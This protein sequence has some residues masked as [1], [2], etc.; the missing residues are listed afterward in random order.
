MGD[1]AATE[2]AKEGWT[3]QGV[4]YEQRRNTGDPVGIIAVRVVDVPDRKVFVESES[5]TWETTLITG[6]KPEYGRFSDDVGGLGPGTYTI[7]PMDIDAQVTVSLARGDFVLVEFALRP[8]PGRTP[9]SGTASLAQP[10]VAAVSAS[11]TARPA[12]THAPGQIVADPAAT[13]S[14]EAGW[15]WQGVEYERKS[16]KETANSTGTIAVRVVEVP[17]RKVSVEAQSGT[18]ATTLVTG[19]KS[20]YGR[21]ADAVGG[22]SP[23]TYVIKPMDIDSEVSVNLDTGDFVLV[24]FA[25]RPIPG[26]TPGS[27]AVETTAE[28]TM[29][30]TSAAEPAQPAPT[31]EPVESPAPAPSTV[32]QEWSWRGVEYERRPRQQTGS[33]A[34]VIAVRVV[35]VPDRKVFIEET[36]GG[37]EATLTTG[38][39]PEYGDF[40]DSVGGLAPGSYTIKPMDIDDEMTVQLEKGDF[41]LVEFALRPGPDWTPAPAGTGQTAASAASGAPTPTLIPGWTW[42]GREVERKAGVETG[43]ATSK[44]VVRGIALPNWL[45]TV[46]DAAGGWE[47][48]VQLEAHPE[49]GNFAGVLEGL[50]PGTYVVDLAGGVGAPAQVSVGQG[51]FVLLEFFPRAA[52]AQ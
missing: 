5:D 49:Y 19:N 38:N 16:G 52:Q 24:E 20:E 12:P 22:L 13:V 45:A 21:F 14:A 8:E 47:M 44:L 37:W 3:W 10:V 43:N 41:V 1:P 39:K 46:S 4:V 31:A 26:W 42:E 36:S 15:I 50:T 7:K 35:G 23:G 9:V 33:I 27:T 18:W 6:R 48:D 32:A 51:D 25:L 17:D 28:P 29:V 11:A 34:G 30:T 2:S 40:S